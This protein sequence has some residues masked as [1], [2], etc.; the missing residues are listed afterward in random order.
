[1][2]EGLECCLCSTLLLLSVMK[3]KGSITPLV[4]EYTRLLVL[5]FIFLFFEPICLQFIFYTTMNF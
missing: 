3:T 1:M 5:N 4:G 2:L